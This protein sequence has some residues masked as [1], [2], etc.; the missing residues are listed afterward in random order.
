[1]KAC[2]GEFGTMNTGR[3]SGEAL[4]R[5]MTNSM[6]T[7]AGRLLSAVDALD[8][9]TIV[10]YIG[11]NGTPMYG[12]PNLDFIDNLYIT[13]KGRGKGTAYESG[14]RVPL[15]IRGPGIA[16]DRESKAIVNVMDLFPT[17]LALAGL[18]PPARVS[19]GDGT[20][21]LGLDGVS[22]VPVLH[23]GARQVRDPDRGYVLTESLNLMTDSTRQVGARNGRYKVICT[24]KVEPAACEFFD[25][26]A[27]PL[28][29]FPLAKP[30]ACDDAEAASP[31]RP[32]WHF[33][34]LSGVI[35]TESFLGRPRV[36]T[37][38]PSTALAGD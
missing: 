9:N 36:A 3:C 30:A 31:S 20:G 22:L 18:Q 14:A 21:K 17:I 5:A 2:G 11:D 6:D 29:E 4:M 15:V 27:D 25:L 37:P 28:E 35:A 8:P 24:E 34:R 26:A 33:C 12:R 16:A 13:R 19:N 38:I 10:I 32:G 23:D 1:M 7:L